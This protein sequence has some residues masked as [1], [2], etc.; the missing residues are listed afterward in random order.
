MRRDSALS[1]NIGLIYEEAFPALG[2]MEGSHL[3]HTAITHTP[4]YPPSCPL[5]LTHGWGHTCVFPQGRS[6]PIWVPATDMRPVT[7]QGYF[8]AFTILV[9]STAGVASAEDLWALIPMPPLLLPIDIY[10]PM[11]PTHFTS[12]ASLGLSFV[13]LVDRQTIRRSLDTGQWALLHAKHV[14]K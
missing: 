9:L 13:D 14:S 4:A 7:D 11:N 1:I 5:M 10:S 3:Q 2:V 6:R 12:S 8:A